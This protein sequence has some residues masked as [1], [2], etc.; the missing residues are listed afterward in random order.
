[1]RVHTALRMEK[2]LYSQRNVKFSKFSA[3]PAGKEVRVIT[4]AAIFGS[5]VKLCF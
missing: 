5:Q 1:L 3:I 4:L 2:K